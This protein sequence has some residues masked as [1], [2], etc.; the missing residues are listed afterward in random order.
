MLSPT[1]LCALFLRTELVEHS[2][3]NKCCGK[4]SPCIFTLALGVLHAFEMHGSQQN[5]SV[6]SSG[7]ITAVNKKESLFYTEIGSVGK[8]SGRCGW[9]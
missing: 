8:F 3:F 7:L 9:F 5:L 2:H 6:W 4:F 1:S